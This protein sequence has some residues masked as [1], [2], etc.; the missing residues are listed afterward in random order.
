MKILRG[1][2]SVYSDMPGNTGLTGFVIIETSHIAVH[3]WDG[4]EP[5][6]MS[7][8]VYTCSELNLEDVF[9]ELQQFNPVKIEYK[10]IDREFELELVSQGIIHNG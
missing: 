7:L 9:E 8:D 6:L 4:V 2:Y 1:P 3:L 5:A 10:F